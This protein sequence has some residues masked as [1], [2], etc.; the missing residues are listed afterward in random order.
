[1]P[2]IEDGEVYDRVTEIISVIEC[3]EKGA[4]QRTINDG[5]KSGKIKRIDSMVTFDTI[6]GTIVHHKI[7]DFLC[8]MM[9]MPEPVH[10]FNAAEEQML[11]QIETNPELKKALDMKVARCYMNFIDFWSEFNP[12]PLAIEQTVKGEYEYVDPKDGRTKSR[13]VKGNIDLVCLI[14]EGKLDK[15]KNRSP[16]SRDLKIVLIDWKSGSQHFST[17]KNQ[18]SAYYWLAGKE[19]LPRLLRK[20]DYY[21]WKDLPEGM[22]VY[23][24]GNA[25]KAKQFELKPKLFFSSYKLYTEARFVPF[26]TLSGRMATSLMQCLY[27]N[28]RSRCSAF[29]EMIVELPVTNGDQETED[30]DSVRIPTEPSILSE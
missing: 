19:L 7:E 21:T 5:I 11:F 6:K 10:R 16:R 8:D 23:L 15:N 28:H 27:C 29:V 14:E 26:N 1:M 4:H 30:M 24:G 9:D 18:L 3:E 13:S 22:D 20:H 17:H 2:H 25:Y 12:I